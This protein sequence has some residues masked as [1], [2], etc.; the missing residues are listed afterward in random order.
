MLLSGN[1]AVALDE[2]TIVGFIGPISSRGAIYRLNWAPQFET[3][4]HFRATWRPPIQGR[5]CRLVPISINKL[6]EWETKSEGKRGGL[7][8]D[9]FDYANKGEERNDCRWHFAGTRRTWFT[10]SL[11]I[12]FLFCSLP[13]LGFS[14]AHGQRGTRRVILVKQF[15]AHVLGS[16]PIYYQLKSECVIFQKRLH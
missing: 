4:S 3:V 8:G 7:L 5:V 2:R 14:T 13:P 15:V 1:D 10:A 12:W 9:W 16:R 11:L 6:K